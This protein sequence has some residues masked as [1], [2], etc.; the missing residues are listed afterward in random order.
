MEKGNKGEKSKLCNYNLI[1]QNI[2]LEKYLHCNNHVRG[3]YYHTALR[4]GSNQLEIERG[5]WKRLPRS[6]RLCQQ[7]DWN[8]IENE[9]HFILKCP[10]YDNFRE[11]LFQK[12]IELTNGKWNFKTSDAEYAFSVLLQ[13]TGDESES[14]IFNLFHGFLERCF[15]LRNQ[16]ADTLNVYSFLYY[17]MSSYIT[18]DM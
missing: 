8:A 17:L 10:K 1:K 18:L 5:R 3:R 12:I 14:T 11:E 15:K 2:K 4:T 16:K 6:Q 13:G 9:E 7:C